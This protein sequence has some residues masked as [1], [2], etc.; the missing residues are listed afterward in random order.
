MR[1]NSALVLSVGIAVLGCLVLASPVLAQA[2]L[3][4]AGASNNAVV[5]PSPGV[6]LP[7]PTQ[8]IVPGLPAGAAAH[9]VAYYGSDNALVSDFGNSRV[10]VV[11]ISTA[12]LVDTIPTSP[13]YN[14]T[15]SI[16]VAPGLNAALA[17]GNSASLAVIAAPFTA[18]SGI[19]TVSLPGT[20]A[21]Y[22]TEAIVFNAAGRAFVWNTAGIS[23][24]D[25]PYSSVAFTIPLGNGASGSIAISPDGNTLIVTDF[26]AS[27]EVFSA[28]FTASSV[29]VPVAVTGASQLDGIAITPDGSTALAV[30]AGVGGN[31]W[32][33][34]APFNASSTTQGIPVPIAAG[35]FE[36]IGISADGQLAIMAGNDLG[37]STIVPFIQAPYTTV[38]ATVSQ[39]NVTGGRGA[40]AV[41]FLP[42]GLAPGLTISKSGPPTGTTGSNITYT[43]T[44]G[45]TGGAAANAVVIHDPVPAGTTFVSATGGGTMAGGV[46]TWNIGTVPAGTTGQTVQFTVTVNVANG[47][48]SNVNYTI[49]GT[50]IPPI[51][52][53]P[54]FTQIGTGGATPTPTVIVATPTPGAG[55]TA[56]IPTLSNEVLA[57]LAV[58]LAAVAFLVLRRQA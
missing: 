30:D 31:L 2:I 14:G 39:V 56:P 16:A 19:T 3:G 53:P 40:G 22:Q 36:D 33:I 54:V 38:G 41:R 58:A 10:F 18:S 46:V 51:P 37:S 12:T 34:S 5:F 52:G 25:P 47:T 6:G 32:A 11:Q 43:I 9:G 4:A 49:E 1:K 21:G 17:C 45:N 57:L 27:A 29:P 28:P 15:G 24:L 48:V 50:G 20:I 23:V 44:Y 7:N 55:P 8:N 35:T 42:P 26:T 13:G